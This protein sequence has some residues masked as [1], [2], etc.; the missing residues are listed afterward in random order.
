MSKNSDNTDLISDLIDDL[1][2]E[3]IEKFDFDS[4][5]ILSEDRI[6][7]L[8][9]EKRKNHLENEYTNSNKKKPLSKVALLVALISLFSIT[10][11][12]ASKINL[13][14]S[15]FGGGLE[16]IESS[17]VEP[18]I[19]DTI[20]GVTM[21][22]EAIVSDGRSINIIIS[23]EG[24]NSI[25]DNLTGAKDEGNFANSGG[26]MLFDLD[27]EFPISRTLMHPLEDLNDT[28]KKYYYLQFTNFENYKSQEVTIS[29]NPRLAPIVLTTTVDNNLNCIE[30]NLENKLT[31]ES[32]NIE[33]L[34]IT[35]I[36]FM[37]TCYGDK[38]NDNFPYTTI[39]L[40]F[41]DDYSETIELE[42]L[43]DYDFKFH[44]TTD[45]TIDS[46]VKF[47]N[48][49][50]NSDNNITFR[51]E[52]SRVIEPKKIEQILINGINYLE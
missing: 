41:V 51:G 3:T 26:F 34:Q 52:F 42:L 8:A 37:L 45:P 20:N 30:L 39:E 16:K 47:L 50:R 48:I 12:A 35:P 49:T 29:L 19:S 22:L 44:G 33:K 1:S 38:E 23:L 5:D 28:D 21:N 2:E 18:V 15:V 24:I 13:F 11:F 4:V 32:I 7:K 46:L 9:K 25:Y 17:I 31:I 6:N 14:Q 10:V 43:P 36:S 40:V 27:V